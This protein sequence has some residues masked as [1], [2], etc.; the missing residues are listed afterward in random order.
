VQRF[1]PVGRKTSKSPLSNLSNQCFVLR[2]ML[3][4]NCQ[5]LPQNYSACIGLQNYVTD[6]VI[7]GKPLLAILK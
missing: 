2:A 4:V 6:H 7:I 5:N 1:A 3:P